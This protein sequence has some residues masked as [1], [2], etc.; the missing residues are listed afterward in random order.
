MLH[1][2]KEKRNNT[3]TTK[4]DLTQCQK[5]FGGEKKKIG[6]LGDK[7][8]QTDIESQARMMNGRQ[9]LNQK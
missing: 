5:D 1:R 6:S 3:K 2:E 8:T 7:G 4:T 9:E